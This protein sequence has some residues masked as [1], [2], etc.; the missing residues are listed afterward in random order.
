MRKTMTPERK[1]SRTTK[2]SGRSRQS[3]S[4]SS[5]ISEVGPIDTSFTVPRNTYRIVPAHVTYDTIPASV[6][7]T[8]RELERCAAWPHGPWL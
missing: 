6:T 3:C 2:S 7:R 1:V 4:V 5:A 8:E